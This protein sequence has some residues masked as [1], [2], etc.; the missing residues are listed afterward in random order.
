[1]LVIS[2][3]PFL[4]VEKLGKVP[5]ILFKVTRLQIAFRNREP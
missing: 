2:E 3:L 5:A 1:M 4:S